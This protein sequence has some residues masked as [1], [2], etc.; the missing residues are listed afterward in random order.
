M[1]LLCGSKDMIMFVRIPEGANNLVK[2]TKGCCRVKFAIFRYPLA[3]HFL[4][5]VHQTNKTI[6]LSPFLCVI[7]Y[8]MT[9]FYFVKA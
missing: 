7:F 9:Y 3:L 8:N 4:F 2:I 1:Y 6:D 5:A